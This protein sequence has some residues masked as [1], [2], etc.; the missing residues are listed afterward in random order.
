RVLK[1]PFSTALSK[2]VTTARC[3]ASVSSLSS[4]TTFKVLAEEKTK[5]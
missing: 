5:S 3:F 2:Q 4:K 1:N